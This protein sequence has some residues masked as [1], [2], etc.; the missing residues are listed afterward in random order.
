[1]GTL[2]ALCIFERLLHVITHGR[3]VNLLASAVLLNMSD[4][5]ASPSMSMKGSHQRGIEEDD[6]RLSISQVSG[7]ESVADFLLFLMH[8]TLSYSIA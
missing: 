4:S 6:D 7:A 8:S 1:M 3:L 2:A 5:I